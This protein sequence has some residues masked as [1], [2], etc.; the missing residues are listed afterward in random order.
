LR[1]WAQMLDEFPMILNIYATFYCALE[2]YNVKPKRLNLVALALAS[3]VQGV[4]YWVFEIYGIFFMCFVVV[5]IF[6]MVTVG[7]FCCKDESPKVV[8]H[9][10]AIIF[11][12]YAV[13]GVLW[14]TET[15]FCDKLKMFNFHALWHLGAGYGMYLYILLLAY[16]RGRFLRKSVHIKHSSKAQ[17]H[18]VIWMDE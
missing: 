12:L 18:Y 2:T 7:H 5:V 11:F 8:K 16:M 17:M 6:Q 4:L 3:A 1:H 14:I 9:V 10:I 13:A 15:M